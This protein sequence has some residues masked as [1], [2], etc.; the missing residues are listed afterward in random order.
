MITASS[1][2]ASRRTET[3][4]RP[5]P[6]QRT[7]FPPSFIQLTGNFSAVT[8]QS[9]K[10]DLLS[11]TGPDESGREITQSLRI[12]R[13][14]GTAP[15]PRVLITAGIHGAEY[16]GI[17]TARRIALELN[18]DLVKGTLTVV[19]LANPGAFAARVPAVNPADGRNLN[20]EFPGNAEGSITQRIAAE[21]T[22]LTLASDFHIDLHGGDVHE[23]LSA[24][25]Y[26]P[27]ACE[28]SVTEKARAAAEFVDVPVRVL[29]Q[30]TTGAYNSSAVLG[31]PSI[32]IERGE[33]GR[34][35]EEG[36]A[37]YRRDV[38]SVLQHLGVIVP[39]ALGLVNKPRHDQREAPV[40]VYAGSAVDG[41]WYPTVRA[42]ES[43]PAGALLG[44]LRD[45][46]GKEV[47]RVHAEFAGTVLYGS[48]TLFV[49]AGRD[50]VAYA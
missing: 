23:C 7:P 10:F 17:E 1:P 32:L 18:P 14:E 20:R 8:V 16:V 26:V 42:G 48:G 47:K 50:L 6:P 45:F 49:P 34:W 40:A 25:V 33:G 9:P 30:A 11:V 35:S 5:T 36:V 28:A 31:I 29:S 15:G 12:R 2:R 39:G 21:I 27:G 44:I 24:Y 43:F 13:I 4:P 37:A 38:A 41:L 3:R 46:E 22:K 19:A